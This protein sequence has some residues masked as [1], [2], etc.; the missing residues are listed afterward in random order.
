MRNVIIKICGV[1]DPEMTE[2][3]ATAGAN[4]IGIIFHPFS[5]RYVTF[6]QA[7]EIAY[8]AYQVGIQP[9]GVFVK[10]SHQ[11]IQNICEETQ[12]NIVQLQGEKAR[13]QHHLLPHKYQRIYVQN[14]SMTGEWINEKGLEYL[15][16]DRDVILIDHENSD[17][18]NSINYSNF[19]YNLPFPWILSGGLTSS[20]VATAINTLKPTGV[21][22]S[23]GVETSLGNK[24]I[25]LIQ[26]FISAARE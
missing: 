15:D 4:L 18:G 21:D 16:P 25:A 3:I 13:S 17:E 12:I 14:V 22:V 26:Q 1:R 10:H 23:S 24:D 5:P 2:K 19:H 11:D 20:N 9:V 6:A 8:V 7:K